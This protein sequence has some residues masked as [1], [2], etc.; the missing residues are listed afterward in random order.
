MADETKLRHLAERVLRNYPDFMLDYDPAATQTGGYR[1]EVRRYKRGYG[2]FAETD[3]VRQVQRDLLQALRNEGFTAKLGSE[4]RDD[5]VIRVKPSKPEPV[6]LQEEAA[7]VIR[8]REDSNQ[9][10]SESAKKT[11]SAT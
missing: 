8:E 7:K 5:F 4:T 11:L 1:L 2:T 3:K 6:N 9:K 10:I